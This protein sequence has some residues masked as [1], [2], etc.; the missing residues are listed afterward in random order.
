MYLRREKSGETIPVSIE[1][2]SNTDYKRIT[3]ARFFFNWKI[4]KEFFVYKLTVKGEADILGLISFKYI[5]EEYRIEIRLLAVA[6]EQTGK[7]KT[8]DRIAGNL[9]TFAAKKAISKYGD[10]AAVSLIPKTILGQYYMD[11]YGFEQAGESLFLEGDS[12][13]K[14]LNAYDDD[15]ERI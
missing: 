1:P 14:L 13:L 11:K 2:V 9:F 15:E 3:K 4:E 8:V 12:M 5:D 10:I 6:K 7:Q